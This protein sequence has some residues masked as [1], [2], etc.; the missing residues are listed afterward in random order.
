MSKRIGLAIIL[1]TIAACGSPT[2]PSKGNFSGTWTGTVTQ[3]NGPIQQ[4]WDY[5][6]TLTQTVNTLTGTSRIQFQTGSPVYFG[7]FKV[8]GSVNT[9][10][11]VHIIEDSVTNQLAPPGG[12]WCLKIED[13]TYAGSHLSGPWTAP[14]CVNFGQIDLV[15]K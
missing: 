7:E 2:G 3:P 1:L 13:L 11:T 10:G 6:L 8:L 5:T 9:N 14:N 12:F 15:K 4:T